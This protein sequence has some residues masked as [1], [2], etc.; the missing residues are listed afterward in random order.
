MNISKKT[1]ISSLWF[2]LEVIGIFIVIQLIR[3]VIGNL[4]AFYSGLSLVLIA[5]VLFLVA[6]FI[7]RSKDRRHSRPK[8]KTFTGLFS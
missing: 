6:F 1:V 8:T 7:A 3:F 5:S 4:N 2:A